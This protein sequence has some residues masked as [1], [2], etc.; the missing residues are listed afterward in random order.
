MS[1]LQT[2]NKKN[3]IRFLRNVGEMEKNL[4]TA[5]EK[6]MCSFEIE[7]KLHPNSKTSKAKEIADSLTEL[8]MDTCEEVTGVLGQLSDP[9]DAELLRLYYLKKYTSKST[10]MQLH[11]SYPEFTRHHNHAIDELGTIMNM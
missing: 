11:L 4:M 5:L 7:K 3:A 6:V 9:V 2:P 8:Y 10:A 1:D